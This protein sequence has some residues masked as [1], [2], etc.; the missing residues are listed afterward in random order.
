MA[1]VD[2][3]QLLLDTKAWLPSSQTLSDSMILAI[4]ETVILRIGDDTVNYPQIRCEALYANATK[5]MVDYSTTSAGLKREKTG[6][7]E[8]EYYNSS[9]TNPWKAY[10]DNL[11]QVCPLFGYVP[12]PSDTKNYSV[13]LTVPYNNTLTSDFTLDC[14]CTTEELKF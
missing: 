6:E 14:V 5:M 4:N 7:V 13:L 11:P 10:I 9:S 2:R 3:D 8:F 1:T 12:V